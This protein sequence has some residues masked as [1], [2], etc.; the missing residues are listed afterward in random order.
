[1]RLTQVLILIGL[2]TSLSACAHHPEPE[3][4]IP[5]NSQASSSS[6]ASQ[7]VSA[8]SASVN[9]LEQLSQVTLS[10]WLEQRGL[11]PKNLQ[12]MST[13]LPTPSGQPPREGPPL[14]A[15]FMTDKPKGDQ[16]A[17]RIKLREELSAWL[18][19]K[20]HPE[21]Q[22]TSVTIKPVPKEPTRPDRIEVDIQIVCRL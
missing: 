5:E 11:M 2:L 14:R 3:A 17:W 8:S 1:M 9:P 10:L 7:P 15:I 4:Q 20:G 18:V 16:E 6:S 19:E 12:M 13:T 22:C 21:G